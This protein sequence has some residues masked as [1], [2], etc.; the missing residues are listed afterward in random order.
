MNLLASVLRLI[1][2]LS[3]KV[4]SFNRHFVNSPYGCLNLLLNHAQRLSEFLQAKSD[5]KLTHREI[6]AISPTGRASPVGSNCGR[7]SGPGSAAVKNDTSPSAVLSA[8]V[9]ALLTVVRSKNSLEQIFKL[10]HCPTVMELCRASHK[11]VRRGGGNLLQQLSTLNNSK[12]WLH[13]SGATPLLLKLLAERP[14]E[15]VIH[16]A[17]TTLCATRPAAVLYLTSRISFVYKQCAWFVLL[18]LWITN[19]W[20]PLTVLRFVVTQC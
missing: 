11:R 10:Q 16:T 2:L 14:D 9:A 20:L 15:F 18:L 17:A 6:R 13:A 3:S 8:T 1:R 7:G 4:P 5:G 12:L 19:G